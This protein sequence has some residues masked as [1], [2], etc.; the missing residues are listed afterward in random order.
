MRFLDFVALTLGG[1]LT[2]ACHSTPA[3][4]AA[5]ATGT[6]AELVGDLERR[7]GLFTLHLDA[8][9]ARV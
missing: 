8:D 6:H 7:E 4:P 5:E 3:T 9:A 1:A 2:T